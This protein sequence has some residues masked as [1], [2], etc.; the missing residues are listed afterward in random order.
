VRRSAQP[1]RDPTRLRRR[2]LVAGVAVAV[3]AFAG[4]ALAGALHVSTSQQTVERFAKEWS[5]GDYAA[6]YSELSPPERA[7]IRRGAFT[8]AYQRA[9]DTATAVS[10]GT[11][12]PRRDGNAYRIPVRIETRIWGPVRGT[13]RVPVT[14]AGI[15]WSHDLVFPGLRRGEKLTRET[16]LPPRGTLLARDKTALARGEAR[17]S[18]LGPIATSITG[19]LGPIPPERKAD[20]KAL[21]IPSDAVVGVSGLERI[22]DE[23]LLGR[24]GGE[25]QAGARSPRPSPSRPRRCGRPSRPPCR[26]PPC[27][28]SATASA[29]SS[30]WTRARAACSR[31]RASGSPASSRPA[32]RSRSSPP[33]ARSRR[34]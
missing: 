4:G 8:R 26:P 30:R 7:R 5:A 9:L 13:V 3:L 25:L 20:L 28:R 17:T 21:G 15:D 19:S 2:V 14:D 10:V 27:R 1:R 16:R 32:R 34:G 31:P 11:G 24:P 6:M 23:R 18:P 12:R 22:F 29:G 33:P